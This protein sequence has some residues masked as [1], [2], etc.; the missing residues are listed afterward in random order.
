MGETQNDEHSQ[1]MRRAI[2]LAEKARGKTAPNP[3]VGCVIVKNG[4]VIAEGWHA[5]AGEPHAEAMAL[6]IAGDRAQGADVYVTLEPCNHYGRTPPCAQALIE[7]GVARVFFGVADPNEVASG[8]GAALR[9]AGIKVSSG[10][11]TEAARALIRAWLFSKKHAR[12]FISGKTAMSLDG[13]TATHAGESKWITGP[14]SRRHAH[15]VRSHVDAVIV[16]V[17][18]ALADD[19]ALTAREGETIVHE[20][21]RIIVDSTAR[22][23]PGLAV[24]QRS[25]RGA[26]LATT[27]AAAASRVK[28]LQE[29]GVEICVLPA[30]ER[31]R[32]DVYSLVDA[33]HERG[34]VH[35]LVEGGAQLLGSFFDADLID[36]LAIYV[37]PKLIGGGSPAFGGAGVDKLADADRYEI[38]KPESLGS[39]LLFCA[40]RRGCGI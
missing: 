7:A 35:L 40:K 1:Y 10:I 14:Q 4:V 17:E 24:F 19:P 26:F 9:E 37:A 18:T 30:D 3:M 39:D 32:V 5:K 38:S 8:G 33:L 15:N 22:A 34:V 2:A 21:L 31:G 12:P 28:S 11:E 25:G 23:A 16:G 36:E 29:M 27:N 20:P 6:Q 13:R